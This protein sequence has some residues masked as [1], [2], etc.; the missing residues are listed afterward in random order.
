MH[1]VID[2]MYSNTERRDEKLALYLQK[3]YEQKHRTYHN[4]G[5]L[6]TMWRYITKNAPVEHWHQYV[7]AVFWH[8]LVYEPGAT[9]NEQRSA[10]AF[11][12]YAKKHPSLLHTD[13]DTTV[14]L[15]MSTKDPHA[16]YTSGDELTV[17]F[18]KADWNGMM[19]MHPDEDEYGVEKH[20][21]DEWERG[22]FLEN[23][24]FGIEKYLTGRRKFLVEARDKGLISVSA[25]TH[26]LCNL[27]RT[28]RVGVMVGTFC[29]CHKG[30]M[31]IYEQACEMF[32]KVVIACCRNP[33]KP[34]RKSDVR[35]VLPY[36]EV[37]EHDGQVVDL[38]HK[39]AFSH[40]AN[41]WRVQPVL[42][43]G[44]RDD[45]DRAYED[46]YVRTLRDQVKLRNAMYRGWDMF[47][48]VHFLCKPDYAH[49]SSTL[50]NG[51]LPE[52]Q[53]MYTPTPYTPPKLEINW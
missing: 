14:R 46:K 18:T 50:V 4:L 36:V 31:Q 39:M 24:R 11:V 22:I 8:D 34:D 42:V 20:W 47:P 26:A 25:A 43:R 21:L 29:P 37:I 32:D 13:A 38:L 17:M 45:F 6:E 3:H 5:H 9:D 48:I 16:A 44:I 2:W 52:D 10:D 28:Y 15:I 40:D 30:H 1:R 7:D 41:G 12:Q 51:L 33:A 35:E 49:V 27:R 19:D 53:V 23:Q